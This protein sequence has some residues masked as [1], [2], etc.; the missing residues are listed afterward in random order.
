[1]Q[2]LRKCDLR[3]RRFNGPEHQQI[4]GFKQ[5][6]KRSYQSGGP[7][8]LKEMR[9]WRALQVRRTPLLRSLVASFPALCQV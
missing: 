9:L 3:S 8:F 5:L 6:P 2:P 7:S 4:W 1:M